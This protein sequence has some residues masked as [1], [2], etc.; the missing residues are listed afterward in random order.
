[1]VVAPYEPRHAP[2]GTYRV[3]VT[4]FQ[5]RS[6]D[7]EPTPFWVRVV[8]DGETEVYEGELH[9]RD[10]RYQVVEFEVR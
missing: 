6:E 10:G 1:M 5:T 9:E 2:P 8:N 4:N 7:E 3:V